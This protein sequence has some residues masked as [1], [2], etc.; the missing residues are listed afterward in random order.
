[1]L[2][3][4]EVQLPEH[5]VAGGNCGIE[6]Q[7]FDAGESLTY[8]VY[9]NAGP[10]WLSGGEIYFKLQDETYNGKKVYHG[11]SEAVTYKSF[12]WFFKIR[13]KFETWMDVSTLQSYKFYRDINEGGYTFTRSYDWNRNT[14]TIVSYYHNTKS[15]K[16][17]TKTLTNAD[18][19]G[20][21]MLSSFYWARTVDFSKYNTGD[22]IPV[23]MA[24]DDKIYQVDIRFEGREQYQTKLGTFN[25]FKVKP[26]LSESTVFGKGEGMTIWVTDD[27]N[28]IPVR[29]ESNLKVGRI[30]AD[31]KSY[32]GNKYDFTSK[33]E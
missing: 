8:K 28:R 19:C 10:M 29:I 15:G 21:D 17:S 1:M 22:K 9:Y 6:T 26:L 31:L 4:A 16:K 24:I 27:Q 25:T 11:I 7:A 18:P 33:V 14:N 2:T 13:D 30:T 5:P 32:A 20:V 12:D 3:D 23:S